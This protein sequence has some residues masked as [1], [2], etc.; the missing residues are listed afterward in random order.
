MNAELKE[1]IS[2]IKLFLM[3]M[4]GTVYVDGNKIEGAFETLDILREKGKTVCF[5][6]NNSS[7]SNQTYVKNLAKMNVFITP[8]EIYTSGEATC[9]FLNRK[10]YGKKVY[11]LATDDVY[12]EFK[13]FGIPLSNEDPDIVVVC[14]D[15][16]LTYEKLNKACEFIYKGKLYVAT[17]P[18]TNCP[19]TVSPMPDVGS[20]IALIDA[21]IGRKPDVI[22]GKP[23]REMAES[24]MAKYGF[25]KHETAMVGDRLYTDIL[26]GVDNGFNSILVMTGETTPLM[27]KSSGIQPTLVLTTFKD[28]LEYI[29]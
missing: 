3:D 27:L 15:T 23:N 21:A 18:D 29:E 6:T 26:F 13:S 16:S 28:I 24:I 7:R 20:F 12:N 8:D 1:K 2:K 17:H 19:S 22:V 9:E 14:F 10:H 25:E 5:V 4:D 11:L